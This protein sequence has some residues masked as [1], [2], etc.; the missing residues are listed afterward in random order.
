VRHGESLFNLPDENGITYSSGK[1]ISVPLTE[2]GRQQAK[3]LGNKLIGKLSPDTSYSIF[4]STAIRA[5]DTA[6]LLFTEL[7]PYYSIERKES[8]E[9]LCELSRGKWE[10]KPKDDEFNNDA[11][12]WQALSSKEKFYFP[13]SS[14]GES[15][16]EVGTRFLSGLKKITDEHQNKTIF[17]A[18]HNAAINALA[19]KLNGKIDEL[20]EVPSTPFPATLMGNCDILA[21][22]LE[23]GAPIEQARIKMH[24][25]SE[26]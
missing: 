8:Y 1:G 9:E 5:Q 11:K 12:V 17:I 16:D 13:V 22:E 3:D 18:T 7:T 2:K 19:F 4:S 25:I 21:I 23:A 6:D 10:G 14:T 24:I 15:Y 20:S 26:K